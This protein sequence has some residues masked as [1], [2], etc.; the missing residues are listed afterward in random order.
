MLK[1]HRI[2]VCEQTGVPP[3]TASVLE[4]IDL[5]RLRGSMTHGPADHIRSRWPSGHAIKGALPAEVTSF[6]GRLH[7]VSR[8]QQ[9]LTQNRLLTLTG[10]GGLGKT[11][12]AFRVAAQMQSSFPDGVCVVDLA[13]LA[14][15]RL[16][17][18]AVLAALGS[19]HDQARPPVSAL[20]DLLAH[21]RLLLL[22]DNCEH[23][24]HASATL[25]RSLLDASPALHVLATSR[26]ALGIEGECVLAVPPLSIPDPD[27]PPPLDA[28][29]RYEAVQL[30][31]ER[32]A[33]VLGGFTLSENDRMA[34]AGLC[35][36]IDG[37]P[38][39]IELAAAWL[40]VLSPQQILDR[41]HDRFGLLT[42]GSRTA[43]DRHKTLGATMDWSFQ[44]CL[45]HEQRAWAMLSVFSGGF[46]LEAAAAVCSVDLAGVPILD[47]VAS[48]VDKSLVTRADE[49]GHVRYRM[50]ETIRQYGCARLD[51][52]SREECRR[53]HR[54][55]YQRL[56]AR[57][58]AA[59]FGPH[60]TTWSIHLRQEHDNIR[61]A[62]EFC[63]NTPQEADATLNLVNS[64][65]RYRPCTGG[66][67][68]LHRWLQ[69]AL[70]ADL[71]PGPTRDRAVRIDG[72]LAFIRNDAGTGHARLTEHQ[73][74]LSTIRDE[75]ELY[76][77]SVQFAGL[78]ALFDDDLPRAVAF[79]E[80]AVDRHRSGNDRPAAWLSLFLL[81][82]AYC[83]SRDPRA[84]SLGQ[85][86]LA[87]SESGGAPLCTSIAQCLLGLEHWLSGRSRHAI[88]VLRQALD[89]AH[90][91]H[92]VLAMA[93]CLEVLAWATAQQ[94]HH[95]Q[96]A[97]LL[98]ASQTFWETS[99][100]TLPGLG[101]LV[102]HHSDC[103]EMLQQSL[104]GAR[105]ASCFT[106]GARLTLDQ[107]V[108]CALE[109]SLPD[110]PPVVKPAENPLTR[111]ERQVLGLVAEGLT[112][113]QIAERLVISPRTAEGHVQRILTKLGYSSRTQAATWAMRNVLGAE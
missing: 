54:D 85:E 86:F 55:Y 99:G 102:G 47:V 6:V 79:L 49:D 81:S 22:L 51:D 11:R 30:F 43:P 110:A 5:R 62:V 109:R 68:E 66:I 77:S 100:I 35:H 93:Q 36:E 8:A 14:S 32:A 74:R 39:A 29:V 70:E 26:H 63:L 91:A 112:D 105:Y 88:S 19:E 97:R 34:V 92:N 83:L 4:Q 27:A 37:I 44:L 16:V 21:R 12:L 94:G 75:P 76:A 52:D 15:G 111:R 50:L 82:L 73:A 84:A 69:R 24:L 96:A 31:V 78:A 103:Q 10:A 95:Q 61:S 56:A 23:V 13:P 2:P 20:A 28:M 104:G 106:E 7:E 3:G 80:E 1:S 60:Q 59:W 64:L 48:L 101:R 40:R 113:K 38:L 108:A 67:D 46:D 90:P 17:A 107:A 87:L 45:P 89:V 33:S 53:R 98:G 25:T 9:L 42:R 41:L 71:E 72:W 18:Q 58:E 65:W 57:A